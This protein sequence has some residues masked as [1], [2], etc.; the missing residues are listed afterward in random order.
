MPSENARDHSGLSDEAVELAQKIPQ[1]VCIML[2]TSNRYC[3]RYSQGFMALGAAELSQKCHKTF[4]IYHA[5]LR[6]LL[7]TFA[8]E[9][10]RLS[11][12]LRPPSIPPPLSVVIYTCSWRESYNSC[13]CCSPWSVYLA[14]ALWLSWLQFVLSLFNPRPLFFSIPM[15]LTLRMRNI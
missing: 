6:T 1:F 5:F 12:S 3:Q 11:I 10:V 9:C 4:T 13:G 15:P 7:A 2:A 14:K 8:S